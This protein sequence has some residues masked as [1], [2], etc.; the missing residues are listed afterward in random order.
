MIKP[1]DRLG[2]THDVGTASCAPLSRSGY[3]RSALATKPGR[4][5][6]VLLDFM[7]CR[8]SHSDDASSQQP[9]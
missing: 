5:M 1:A 4:I 3:N 8:G 7:I 2:R 6:K 9:P